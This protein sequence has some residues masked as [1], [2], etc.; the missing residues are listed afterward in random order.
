MLRFSPNPNRANMIRWYDWGEEAFGAARKQ[1]KPVMLFLSAFWCRYCQRMDEEAFSETE[2]I[3]LLRAYFIAIR[4]ENAQRPDV[5]VRYNQNGW[6]TIVFMTPQGEA[7]VAANYLT[8]DQL[9][10]LLLR[11]YVG[12]QQAPGAATTTPADSTAVSGKSEAGAGVNESALAEIRESIMALADRDHGGYGTG[13]KFIQ[14]EPNDFLLSQYQATGNAEYLNHVCFTLDRMRNQA[15]HD[16]REGGYFRT[17]TGPDWDQPHREKLLAEQA[18]L[19]TNCLRTYRMTRRPEYARMAEDI[20]DYL[21]AKLYDASTGAFYG[22]EDFLR[23]NAEPSSGDEFFTIIDK[24]IYT[25]ANALAIIAYLDAAA[26]LENAGCQEHA[27][28]AL[29]FLRIHC[30]NPAG[31]MFHYLDGAAQLGGWIGDQVFMGKALLEA[32]GTT[33]ERKY[34]EQARELAEFIV[35]RFKKPDGGYSDL[36]ESGFAYLSFRLT[37]I[38]QNGPAASFFLQLAAVTGDTRW[39]E[40]ALWALSAF[41]EN[42]V[43]YGIHAAAFGR[44]LNEYLEV[45]KSR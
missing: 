32:Y 31:G 41:K 3:A 38:E 25:D 5:D 2:N 43:S 29:E 30:A 6:P 26:I 23:V 12:Y 19:I 37:L 1:N 42:L 34:L 17:S 27:L 39:R 14:P 11:V 13:Q 20:V 33:G 4:A 35:A 45:E 21:N 8:S 28:R 36:Q 18:G 44:A 10:D 24:C 40:A 9:Q 16:R 15:I 22:C 7:I